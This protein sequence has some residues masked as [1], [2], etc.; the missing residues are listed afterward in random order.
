M[1]DML[2][3]MFAISDSW[4]LQSIHAFSV[5]VLQPRGLKNPFAYGS[6]GKSR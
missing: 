3:F 1:P 4:N 6:F 5:L 2:T